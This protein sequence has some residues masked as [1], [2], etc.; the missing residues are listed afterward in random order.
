[1]A[2]M[3]SKNIIHSWKA[4]FIDGIV[5]DSSGGKRMYGLDKYYYE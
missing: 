4:A 1:M 2:F 3:I 5:E